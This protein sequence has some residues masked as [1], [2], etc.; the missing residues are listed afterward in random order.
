MCSVARKLVPS[1][2]ALWTDSVR[3]EA[4]WE[5]IG[6]DG[7][8]DAA[9][10]AVAG[11]EIVEGFCEVFGLK[12]GPHAGREE[13]LGVG[14]FPEEEIA[15]AAF[16]SG[17][18][19]QIDVRNRSAGIGD[20]AEAA[21][22]FALRDF[23]AGKHPAG[24]TKNGVTRRVVNGDAKI[25]RVAV[26]GDALGFVDGLGERARNAVAASD[27]AHAD[28]FGGATRRVRAQIIFKQREQGAD[29]AGWALPI[30][31]GEG[32]ES[33]DADAHSRR[34]ANDAS[35][36]GDARAMSLGTRHAAQSRPASVAIEK[37]G[38]VQLRG[39]LR[40][41]WHLSQHKGPYL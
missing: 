3:R 9:E 11:E 29:F 10:A 8:G 30:I 16:A 7:F 25:E 12:I 31:R 2:E 1:A 41:A 27:D 21:A 37:N 38:D 33:K 4:R 6:A 5:L 35:H 13:K 26:S 22:K 24:G 39:S 18:D 36:G 17:A 14:A 34:G 28:A 19:E 23:E 32:V 20:F 15:E 40:T